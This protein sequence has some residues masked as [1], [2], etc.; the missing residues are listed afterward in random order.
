[1]GIER[2]SFQQIAIVVHAGVEQ[3]GDWLSFL[4]ARRNGD[5]CQSSS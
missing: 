4:S 3:A 1:M 2:L 5:K